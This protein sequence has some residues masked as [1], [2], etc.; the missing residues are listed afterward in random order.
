MIEIIEVLTDAIQKM[1][2]FIIKFTPIGVFSLVAVLVNKLDFEKYNE[3]GNFFL[4]TGVGM[5]IHA[6]IVIPLVL[7]LMTRTNPLKYFLLVREAVVVAF[8]SQSSSA[9]MPVTMRVL[10]ENANVDEKIY[11]VSVPIGA[12]L[13]MDGAAFYHAILIMFMAACLESI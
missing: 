5:S 8:F 7:W 11:G 1:T 2:E 6:L 4:A 13:N 10:E 12:T 3:M 9:T